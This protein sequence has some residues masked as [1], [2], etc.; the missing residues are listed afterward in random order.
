MVHA[1]RIERVADLRRGIC[2][3]R[4]SGHPVTT[5][6]SDNDG[7]WLLDCPVKP[8][9]DNEGV[10]TKLEL[11]RAS[12]SDELKGPKAA[13]GGNAAQLVLANTTSREQLR[14]L[15]GAGDL[16]HGAADDAEFQP[17]ARMPALPN[18]TS[19]K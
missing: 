9:N 8:G 6:V 18:T 11:T 12:L 2:H 5:A 10:L 16:V 3:A 17:L 15:G 1:I 7:R 4:K 19:P 13:R 14:H